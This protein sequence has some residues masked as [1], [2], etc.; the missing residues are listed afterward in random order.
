MVS[1]RSRSVPNSAIARS[2]ASLSRFGASSASACETITT[3]RGDIIGSVRTAATSEPTPPASRSPVVQ[4]PACTRSTLNAAR[5]S[6]T[7]EVNCA[8]S[9][10]FSTSSS[11]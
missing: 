1:G 4:S 11:P 8:A 6:S 3:R 7:S 5:P 10:A 9:A 2:A